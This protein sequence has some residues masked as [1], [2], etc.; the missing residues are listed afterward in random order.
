MLKRP[1]ASAS[2]FQVKDQQGSEVRKKRVKWW[3]QGAG[4]VIITSSNISGSPCWVG[5][6]L[7]IAVVL[8]LTVLFIFM[9]LMPELLGV[10]SMSCG[11]GCEL[12]NL[13][14]SLARNCSLFQRFSTLLYKCPRCWYFYN[15]M[16]IPRV[17]PPNCQVQFKIKK[18]TPLRL[19]VDIERGY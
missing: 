9:R 6:W 12:S 1:V 11:S 2:P 3:S 16:Q 19:T 8:R 5:P 7:G 14:G 10:R 17:L 18:T 4:L 15:L 13:V